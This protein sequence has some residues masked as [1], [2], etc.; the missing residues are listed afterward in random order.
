[1]D[2]F[3]LFSIVK[4]KVAEEIRQYRNFIADFPEGKD[5]LL[6]TTLNLMVTDTCNS[7]CVMCNIWN[8]QQKKE[9]TIEEFA[10]ILKDPL[11]DKIKYIGVSGG[12]PTLREDLPEI[13]RAITSRKGIR[14]VSLITNALMADAVISQIERC[15]YVCKEVNVPFSAMISL[16]GIGRVHDL[17]R[18][19]DGSFKSALKVIRHVRDKTDIPLSVACTVVKENVWHLDEVLS[20]C[21]EEKLYGRFRIAEFINRL[22]N[23]GLKDT[24]RNFDNDERYQI[25]IFFSKLELTY[26]NDPSVRATYRNIRRMVFE[27]MHRES[28]CPYRSVAVGLDSTGNLIFCSPKSPILSSCIKTSALK[29]YKDNIYV[30]QNIIKENCSNCIHDYHA[31]PTKAT[32]KE[33]KEERYCNVIFSVKKALKDSRKIPS[34]EPQEHDWSCF[35]KPLIIGWY[36]TE[37]A[38]DKAIL[39][40]IINKLHEANNN[41]RIT[42]A[43]LFPFVTKRTLYE[44]NVSATIIKTYSMEYLQ[45]CKSADAVIMGGGP[46]MGME[47]LGFV[48]KAFLTA[49]QFNIP[50]IVEGCGIGPLSDKEHIS[51]VKEILR[52]STSIKV[53]DMSSLA[54]VVEKTKRNDAVCSGDPAASFVRRWKQENSPFRLTLK[55]NSFACFLREITY[56]YANEMNSDD[57]SRFKIKFEDELGKMVIHLVEK[58]NIKPIFI[59]M[60][61]FAIGMD[62]RD[63]ARR[64]VKTYLTGYENELRHK[65]YSPQDILSVMNRSKFNLC[66]R[67]HSVLFADTLGAPFIAIDYTGGGKIKSYLKDRQKDELNIDRVDLAE[68]RWREAVDNALSKGF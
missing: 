46:L 65:V 9:F 57:F 64:F 50:T 66:M 58:M 26:E 21:H 11:F 45:A 19:R 63:F 51:A 55:E 6:P 20:F 36:G 7:H 28:G 34:A 54:W 56:E 52:L 8:N 1:M 39:G 12:E 22:Y 25:A 24:I 5:L 32:L 47:P 31:T 38:G 43:S 16:D 27:G 23:T 2:I 29:L 13:F 17:V 37:T 35:T 62:D 61:T 10:E 33:A 18:G 4:K 41:S 53:R 42:I 49:K 15:C 14:G 60:H 40:S 68:G 48:L 67:F 30:R 59:P 3:N 44:L